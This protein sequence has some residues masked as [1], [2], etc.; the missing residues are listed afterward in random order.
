MAI[1]PRRCYARTTWLR[2]PVPATTTSPSP[3][4][5]PKASPPSSRNHHTHRRRQS[6]SY[7]RDQDK[8]SKCLPKPLHKGLVRHSPR[9]HAGLKRR[10]VRLAANQANDA[11][12]LRSIPQSSC[13]TRN[14]RGRPC[15]PI[16]GC[17]S[18]YRLALTTS[19]AFS[20]PFSTAVGITVSSEAL[21]PSFFRNSASTRANVS[22]FSF[23]YP[24]TF[25]RPW[26]IRSPW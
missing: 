24:R 7:W 17:E 4:T 23:K 26:P 8:F 22:L 20:A 12:S 15:F 16:H 25:S 11:R 1:P 6:H 2:T 5:H 19:C 14:L 18:R 10:I 21:I 3:A 9:A 13:R